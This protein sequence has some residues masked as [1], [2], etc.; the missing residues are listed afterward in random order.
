MARERD[1]N[2]RFVKGHKSNGGRRKEPEEFKK[3]CVELT[4]DALGVLKE[5]MLNKDQPA[6]ARI[7]AAEVILDRAFGKA[8]QALEIDYIDSAITLHIEGYD[9]YGD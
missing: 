8:P 7:K 1:K 5:I 9:G 4:M 3:A 2:G 6:S